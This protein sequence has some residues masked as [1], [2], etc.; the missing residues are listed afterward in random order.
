MPTTKEQNM[1][2][3]NIQVTPAETLMTLLET[4]L[5]NRE[6]KIA[7]INKVLQE[8]HQKGLDDG[9]DQALFD[10]GSQQIAG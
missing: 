4:S 9:Y 6:Q 5:L 7:Q 8:F 3:K 10:M 1:T 2:T